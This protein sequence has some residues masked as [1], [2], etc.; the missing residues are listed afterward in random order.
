M[1]WTCLFRWMSGDSHLGLCRSRTAPIAPSTHAGVSGPWAEG[2][3][4][5][6]HV[7]VTPMERPMLGALAYRHWSPAPCGCAWLRSCDRSAGHGLP[8]GSINGMDGLGMG[9]PN[10]AWVDF[11]GRFRG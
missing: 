7:D 9:G 3:G 2:P 10:W 5:W 4:R 6:V 8:M 1:E 11:P